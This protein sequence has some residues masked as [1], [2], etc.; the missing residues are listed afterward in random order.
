MKEQITEF[1]TINPLQ[2]PEEIYHRIFETTGTAMLIVEEDTTIFMINTEFEKLSG[3]SKDEVE[4]KKSWTEFYVKDDLEKMIEYNHLRINNPNAAPNKYESHF[5]DRHGNVKNVLLN[6]TVF[7]ETKR[8]VASLMDITETKKAEEGLKRY[9]ILSKH[10]RDILLFVQRD[11]QIIEGNDAALKAYGYTRSE[12]ISLSIFDLRAPETVSTV[13]EQM[14]QA[15]RK[16]ILFET[17]HRRKDGSVFPVEVSSQG[18]IIGNNNVLLSIIRDITYRKQVE[19]KLRASEANYRTIFNTAYDAILVSDIDSGKILDSNQK[20]CEMYGYTQEEVRQLSIEE[21]SLGEPPYGKEQAQQFIKKA[22]EDEPQI[23]EWMAK[24]KAG[25]LFW[26]E[27]TLKRVFI[28]GYARLL[29]VVR[30]ISERK[31][32]EKEL[33]RLSFLDGL[34]GIA[35]RRYFHEYLEKELKQAVRNATPLSLIM[36][37]L[38]YFK[39]YNDTYGHLAGDKCLI[40]VASALQSALKRPTDITARYGG[41]EFAIILPNTGMDGSAKV[42]ENLRSCIEGLGIDHAGSL[43]SKYVTISLGVATF[44]PK[45]HSSSMELINASDRA[46]YQA[47]SEGRNRAIIID[48]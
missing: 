27:L 22:N 14:E 16:G 21:L 12:L 36:S 46:L 5:V 20:M 9:H 44:Y 38:D 33:Q 24:N 15:D 35:N 28:N 34:T 11:G 39:A 4:S 7:P 23:F 48:F 47:K 45:P 37:D 32:V 42:A 1:Q 43:V 6:V 13:E 3:Y 25:R 26:V 40:K 29:S 19:E 10:A 2:A 17:I 31:K 18:T 8:C 30:D 41:E